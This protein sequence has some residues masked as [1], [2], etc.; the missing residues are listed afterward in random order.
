MA[1]GN[2]SLVYGCMA[3]EEQLDNIQMSMQY[4]E[5]KRGSP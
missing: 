3:I 2:A 4:C 1:V 5:M